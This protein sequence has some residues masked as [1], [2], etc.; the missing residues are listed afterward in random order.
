M[1]MAVEEEHVAESKVGVGDRA[2]DFELTD[3]HLRRVRLADFRGTRNVLLVFYPLT[4]TSVCGGELTA[5][6]DRLP[7]FEADEV[8]VL[9]VSSDSSA[10]H[11]TYVDRE[12]LGFQLL[13]DFWPHGA[14][15]KAYGV[16]DATT[17]L[18]Q[19]ATFLINK[20]GVISW[21]VD[22]DMATARN[23]EDY[24]AAIAAL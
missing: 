22:A 13:S 10:V 3:D 16:F 15:A 24:L 6:R 7:E 17:G 2:P 12:Y 1:M 20:T 11:R 19:R 14:A 5:L 4:F 23:T 8:T 21:T 18:A 9:G